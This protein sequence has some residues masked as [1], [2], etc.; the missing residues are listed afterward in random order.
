MEGEISATQS[1]FDS[2]VI[3]T[4]ALVRVWKCFENEIYIRC[5][6]VARHR[7]VLPESVYNLRAVSFVTVD[8][9]R[10]SSLSPVFIRGQ[11]ASP[12]SRFSFIPLWLSI[13]CV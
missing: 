12:F 5:R 2:I 10:L 13:L 9:P 6:I 8:Q 1:I 3:V 4:A 7:A 11:Q